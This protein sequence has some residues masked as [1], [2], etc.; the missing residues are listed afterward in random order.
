MNEGKGLEAQLLGDHILVNVDDAVEQKKGRVYTIRLTETES[1][2]SGVVTHVGPGYFDEDGNQI[3]KMQVSVGDVVLFS[4]DYLQIEHEGVK[5][6]AMR[7]ANVI[8]IV[9]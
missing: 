8:G 5:A 9:K 7:E 2:N 4:T 3:Y 6:I 1:M